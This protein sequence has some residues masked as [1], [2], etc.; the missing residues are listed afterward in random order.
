MENLTPAEALL[1]LAPLKYI[2][3][4]CFSHTFNLM[5]YVSFEILYSTGGHT[6]VYTKACMFNHYIVGILLLLL[7]CYFYCY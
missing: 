7:F 2:H 5:I 1:V 3:R 4:I 6:A